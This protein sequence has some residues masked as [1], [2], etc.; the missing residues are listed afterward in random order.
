MVAKEALLQF[1]LYVSKLL[2]PTIP[3]D[4]AQKL[5]PK[6][7]VVARFDKATNPIREVDLYEHLAERLNIGA[8]SC[9]TPVY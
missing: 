4:A 3:L 8:S 7:S 5:V 6:H 1:A 2:R 9:S